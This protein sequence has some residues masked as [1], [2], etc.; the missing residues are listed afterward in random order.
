MKYSEII[1]EAASTTA[2]PVRVTRYNP[3]TDE[4]IVKHVTMTFNTAD[5]AE[6]LEYLMDPNAD[7]TTLSMAQETLLKYIPKYQQ[8]SKKLKSK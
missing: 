7:D 6:A 3:E 2:L 4:S 8:L 1:N 5:L